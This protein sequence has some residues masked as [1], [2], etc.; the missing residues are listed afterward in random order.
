[1]NHFAL[2]LFVCC[3]DMTDGS[4]L[5]EGK[6]ILTL[7]VELVGGGIE[8]LPGELGNGEALHDFV[9]SLVA[10]DGIGEDHALLD[11]VGAVSG[12]SHG[13]ELALEGKEPTR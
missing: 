11:S 1:M 10:G 8:H 6:S 13:N 4:V 5:E 12:D 7:R 2:F 3:L 9:G